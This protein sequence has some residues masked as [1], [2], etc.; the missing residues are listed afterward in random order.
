MII[1]GEELRMK[2]RRCGHEFKHIIGYGPVAPTF[3]LR[4]QKLKENPPK[5]PKCG[6]MDVKKL[7]LFDWLFG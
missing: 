2:C 5:C 7:T 6:S 1:D 4:A 3:W